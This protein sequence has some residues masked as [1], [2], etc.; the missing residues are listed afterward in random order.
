MFICKLRVEGGFNIK[1]ILSW[2]KAIF[3]RWLWFIEGNN[4]SFW[5]RWVR[6]YYFVYDD[7]WSI[8]KKRR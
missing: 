1:E 8:K 3:M 7:I 5:I 2:N 6:K 4:D